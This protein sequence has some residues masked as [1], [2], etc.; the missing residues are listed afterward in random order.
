MAPIITLGDHKV[1]LLTFVKDCADLGCGYL[2][3]M[4]KLIAKCS[5]KIEDIIKANAFLESLKVPE[6]VVREAI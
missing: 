1:S 2:G 6:V 5:Y 4:S 3:S